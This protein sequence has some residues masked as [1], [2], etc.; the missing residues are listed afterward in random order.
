MSRNMKQARLALGQRRQPVDKHG[1]RVLR[2]FTPLERQVQEQQDSRER[3]PDWSRFA[4][5]ETSHGTA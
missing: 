5:E 4:E 1:I 2:G 3:E